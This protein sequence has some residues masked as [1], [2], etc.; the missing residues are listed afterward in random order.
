[1]AAGG[2]RSHAAV[3]ADPEPWAA[4]LWLLAWSMVVGT[5]AYALTAIS[6]VDCGG[7]PET[8]EPAV[9]HAANVGAIAS[10]V[11]VAASFLVVGVG[12]VGH[13]RPIAAGWWVAVGLTQVAIALTT[14]IVARSA[15]DAQYPG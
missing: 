12:C 10:A 13:R 1:M 2:Y 3:V 6:T 15:V 8:C 4:P 7:T 14:Y 5:F 11:M 9:Y